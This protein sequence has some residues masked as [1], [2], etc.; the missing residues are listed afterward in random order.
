MFLFHFK[1]QFE[2]VEEATREARKN[3]VVVIV[4]QK[5]FKIQKASHA[6]GSELFENGTKTEKIKENTSFVLFDVIE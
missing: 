4:S 3:V 5:C 6:I 1:W 2:H